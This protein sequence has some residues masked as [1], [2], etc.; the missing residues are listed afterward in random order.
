MADREAENAEDRG[1]ATPEDDS[2]PKQ[3]GRRPIR[4]RR[5]TLIAVLLLLVLGVL[6][7]LPLYLHLIS[8]ESTDDAFIEGHVIT[9]SPRVAGHVQRLLIDDNQEVRQNDLLLE[10]DPRDFEARL[11]QA[12]AALL[13]AQA[14]QKLAQIQVGLT[15]ITSTAG[16]TQASSGVALEAS[17]VLVTRAQLAAAQSQATQAHANYQAALKQLSRAEADARAARARAD[18]ANADL[19]RYN[20]LYAEGVV[21]QQQLDEV[22]SAARQENAALEAGRMNVETARSQVHEAQAAEKAAH[23][24]VEAARSAIGQAQARVGQAAGKLT[25][26]NVTPQRVASSQSQLEANT[27][28]VKR[29]EALL[30]Q[31]ELDLSYTKIYA[32]AEGKITRKAVEPGNYVQVGQALSALVPH[33]VWVVANFKETQLNHMRPGQPAWIHVDAYPDREFKGHVD[34]LQSGTGARFSLLPPE[35]ATGNFIKVVQRV[36][37]KIVFDEQPERMRL[38]A[39]GMSVVPKVKVR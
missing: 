39:P 17:G 14:Q 37:V 35:N 5:I 9:L 20:P 12:R 1:Q 7:G 30:R 34:S 28:D 21:S 6:V 13:V 29:L 38:L 22:S 10:I 31:A 25:E 15:T 27:A 2:T 19:R 3:P 23:D 11:A 24:A 4:K 8:Y 18:K 16:V 36:P 33:E 32:P 26:V